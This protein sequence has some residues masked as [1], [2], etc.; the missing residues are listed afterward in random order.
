MLIPLTERRAMKVNKFVPICRG[1]KNIE[2][3]SNI[4]K[5]EYAEFQQVRVSI[6]EL[7]PIRFLMAAFQR[8][9]FFHTRS[10]INQIFSISTN[11][12]FSD[13][14]FSQSDGFTTQLSI[15]GSFSSWIFSESELSD[16]AFSSNQIR[17]G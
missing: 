9:R 7:K 4:I 6:L 1:Q 8:I 3:K 15:N 14:K 11:E 2:V 13:S 5:D 12:I 10:S 16:V 17:S